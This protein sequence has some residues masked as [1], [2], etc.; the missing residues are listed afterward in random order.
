MLYSGW[1]VPIAYDIE[2][3][4]S[5]AGLGNVLLTDYR[6]F[7]HGRHNWFDKKSKTSAIIGLITPEI[8]SLAEK[9]FSLLPKEIPILKIETKNNQA[10]SSVELLLQSFLLVNKVGE[11]MGIDPG[12]PGVPGYGSKLYH[13]T[14]PKDL[15][16]K[17]KTLKNNYG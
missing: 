12:R 14:Y 11:K 16:Q 9:T 1:S 5:E 17:I 4:F 3:K 6:N 10:S 8:K 2:S 13:L 7:G 15:L